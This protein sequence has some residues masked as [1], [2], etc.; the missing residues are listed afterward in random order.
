MVSSF[1]WF[2]NDEQP[3]LSFLVAFSVDRQ[4]LDLGFTV[5]IR[6]VYKCTDH[7]ELLSKIVGTWKKALSI[8]LYLDSL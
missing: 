5:N 3:A 4:F 7:T 1:F 2:L 6:T 8:V